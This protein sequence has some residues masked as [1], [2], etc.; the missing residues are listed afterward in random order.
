MN[1]TP[2][3]LNKTSTHGTNILLPFNVTFKQ[4]ASQTDCKIILQIYTFSY[5]FDY[6]PN[7][8]KYTCSY[9]MISK[10]HY[11]TKLCQATI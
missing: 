2:F 6:N 8:S 7:N 4:S 11:S 3:Y 10:C 1:M 5:Y 9:R